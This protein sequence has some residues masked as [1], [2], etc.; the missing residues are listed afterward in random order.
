[1]YIYIFCLP[2]EVVLHVHVGCLF[3]Y[4]N[5]DFLQGVNILW[6]YYYISFLLH[7]FLYLLYFFSCFSSLHFYLLFFILSFIELHKTCF[8]RICLLLSAAWSHTRILATYTGQQF[9]VRFICE[10]SVI[11][12]IHICTSGIILPCTCY[13]PCNKI[14]LEQCCKE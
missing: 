4:L 11:T 8:L 7:I 5:G 13:I 3:S 14:C 9:I 6:G 2:S 12:Y 1:M 10:I